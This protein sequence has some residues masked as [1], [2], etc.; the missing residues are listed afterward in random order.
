M[1]QYKSLRT[2]ARLFK[3]LAY[4][5]LVIG[6]LITGVF[7]LSQV[8]GNLYGLLYGIGQLLIVLLAFLFLLAFSEF[9]M[10]GINVANDVSITADNSYVIA[11]KAGSQG[12]EVSDEEL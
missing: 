8:G 2:V 3:V 7:T 9:I 10:L 4:T 12:N 6:L 11:R 5:S 1:T